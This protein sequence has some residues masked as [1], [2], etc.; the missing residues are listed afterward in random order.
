MAAVQCIKMC[1]YKAAHINYQ[2][3]VEKCDLETSWFL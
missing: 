3:E 2:N 1:R